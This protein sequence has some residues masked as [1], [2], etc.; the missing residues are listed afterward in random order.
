MPRFA[1]TANLL[2]VMQAGLE[3]QGL[4]PRPWRPCGLL[5]PLGPWS[6]TVKTAVF[7]HRRARLGRC[8]R[9]AAQRLVLVT[10]AA[11][12]MEGRREVNKASRLASCPLLGFPRQ[13]L[14]SLTCPILET[15]KPF[16]ASRREVAPRSGLAGL[17]SCSSVEYKSGSNFSYF[18]PH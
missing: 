6:L 2:K 3:E 9:E 16:S 11:W 14:P 4:G 10:L 13:A 12:S 8:T 1:R 18:W 17:A 7:S 5:L 15:G